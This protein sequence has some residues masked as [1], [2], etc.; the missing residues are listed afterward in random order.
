MVRKYLSP[1][2]LLIVYNVN[3]IRAALVP[4]KRYRVIAQG[5]SAGL[6]YFF[7]ERPQGTVL[8]CQ[9]TRSPPLYAKLFET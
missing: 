7:N 5:Q 4:G 2:E 3:E 8:W 1:F 6:K 9:A